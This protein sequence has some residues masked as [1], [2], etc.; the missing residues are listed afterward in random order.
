MAVARWATIV[1]YAA[2]LLLVLGWETAWAPATPLPRVFWVVVKVVP[3]LVPLP[4]L[5]R[6]NPY[7]HVLTSLLVLVYFCGSVTLGYVAIKSGEMNTLVYATAEATAAVGFVLA[8]SIYA[9]ISFRK[10]PVRSDARTES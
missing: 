10:A 7:A 1:S 4:W 5:V 3:L 8:A 6:G 2:L 9:R